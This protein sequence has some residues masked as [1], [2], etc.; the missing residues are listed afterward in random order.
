[1]KKHRPWQKSTGHL[2][3]DR[4]VRIGP[5]F[6]IPFFSILVPGF[7][8]LFGPGR[9]RVDPIIN[10]FGPG[11]G[12]SDIWNYLGSGSRFLDFFKSWSGPRTR[13]EALDPRPTGF[14]LWIPV[15]V[16]KPK[17]KHMIT[18]WSQRKHSWPKLHWQAYA[19]TYLIPTTHFTRPK[20]T[21]N[22]HPQVRPEAPPEAPPWI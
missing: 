3:G 21:P 8:F 13:T 2:N 11:P 1:M 14:G 22:K 15:S 6:S 10:L 20:I 16:T 12:W 5:R 18:K 7:E 19:A 17:F 9:V 4:P